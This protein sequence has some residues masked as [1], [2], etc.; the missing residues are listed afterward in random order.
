MGVE[1][2]GEHARLAGTIFGAL[3]AAGGFIAGRWSHLV[4]AHRLAREDLVSMTIIAEFYGHTGAGEEKVI[5]RMVGASAV[6]LDDFFKNEALVEKVRHAAQ[7]HPG[8]MR[9]DDPIAHRLMMDE[10]AN[11]LRGLD[12]AANMDFLLGKPTV[13]HT[14]LIAFAADPL[15]RVTDGRLH[16]EIDRLRLIVLGRELAEHVIARGEPADHADRHHRRLHDVAHAWSTQHKQP[17]PGTD[18]VWT[19]EVRTRA[20]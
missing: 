2:T 10:G 5:E 17:D 16:E 9:L 11:W 8:L 13:S 1:I 14:M 12:A 18:R 6:S 3:L 15:E 19:V 7:R 4:L 20:E